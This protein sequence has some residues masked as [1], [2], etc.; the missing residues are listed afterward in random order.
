MPFINLNVSV[1]LSEDEKNA[2]LTSL[3][4][5]IAQALGKPQQYMMVSIE[6][7]AM[8]M[9]GQMGGAAFADIRSIG[10]LSS[11]TN[12]RISQDVCTLLEERLGIAP[13]RV[14]LNFTDISAHNWGWDKKTFG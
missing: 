11:E 5:T 6:T 3:S 7:S 14:Y 8:M 1:P 10:G 12:R 2:L 9:S 13:A 4:T